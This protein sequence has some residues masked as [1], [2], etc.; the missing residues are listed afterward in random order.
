VLQNS[1]NAVS[2]FLLCPDRQDD[3]EARLA[4]HHA[5]VGLGSPLERKG[6]VHGADAG[7]IRTRGRLLQ[8][9][10]G[11]DDDAARYQTAVDGKTA[12]F[13][14]LDRRTLE[15]APYGPAGNHLTRKQIY[16]ILYQ[17]LDPA[18]FALELTQSA[19]ARRLGEA[20]VGGVR[21]DVVGVDYAPGGGMDG[22]IWYLG[23]EDHL[24]QAM[25]A[26]AHLDLVGGY[27]E[28]TVRNLRTDL[29]FAPEE[30]VLTAPE[31]FRTVAARSE[32]DWSLRT[33]DGATVTLA[34]LRGKVTVLDFW[35]SHCPFCKE[36]VRDEVRS[37]RLRAHSILASR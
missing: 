34:D 17:F 11:H 28:F 13:L 16:E 30:F 21:C 7:R 10:A 18:P 14:D 35:V 32:P 5:V 1:T 15:T 26:Y 4:A 24:P 8:R 2:L 36:S 37:L 12:Y 27:F 22:A 29:R 6:L 31:W 25:K 9:P 23:R 19:A 20:E 33:A 3:A